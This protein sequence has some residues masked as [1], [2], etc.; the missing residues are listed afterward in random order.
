[1]CSLITSSRCSPI[2]LT[3]FLG[4]GV[5]LTGD[6][7]VITLL[8]TCDAGVP[9]TKQSLPHLRSHWKLVFVTYLKFTGTTGQPLSKLPFYSSH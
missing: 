8:P 7:T 6:G 3:L 9:Q 4:E 2:F 1:M 5:V